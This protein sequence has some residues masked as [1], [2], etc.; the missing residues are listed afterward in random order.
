MKKYQI[1]RVSI[2]QDYE[3]VKELDEISKY[4]KIEHVIFYCENPLPHALYK[5]YQI[6]YTIEE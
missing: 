2:Q 5:I 1:R 4:G 6:I 3:L